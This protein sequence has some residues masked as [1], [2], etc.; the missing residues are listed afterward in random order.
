MRSRVATGTRVPEESPRRGPASGRAVVCG[1]RPPDAPP[2]RVGY[3]A[4]PCGLGLA[5]SPPPAAVLPPRALCRSMPLCRCRAVFRGEGSG[6]RAGFPPPPPRP[7]D[8]AGG[9]PPFVLPAPARRLRRRRGLP[10]L[11]PAWRLIAASKPLLAI[12]P[13]LEHVTMCRYG[14]HIV[15]C[16][17]SRGVSRNRRSTIVRFI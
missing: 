3:H 17:C 10:P 15:C 9:S 14:V 8:A 13:S 16:W 6:R 7:A 2:R 4:S 12:S 1:G 11:P 5:L